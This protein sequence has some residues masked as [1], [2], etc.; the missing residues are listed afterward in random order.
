MVGD[1]FQTPLE[2]EVASEKD[3]FSCFLSGEHLFG[4]GSPGE[5]GGPRAMRWER[6]DGFSCQI[7]DFCVYHVEF[8]DGLAFFGHEGY[9]FLAFCVEPQR[10]KLKLVI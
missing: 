5:A 2:Q 10:V 6:R 1:G 9:G 4:R 3:Y 7:S 8:Q